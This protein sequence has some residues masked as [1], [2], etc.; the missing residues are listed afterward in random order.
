MA[1][2]H[3]LAVM[4][5]RSITLRIKYI[6][7]ALYRLIEN[8]P[9]ILTSSSLKSISKP[10]THVFYGYYDISPFNNK[11]DEYIFCN[12]IEKENKIHIMLSS[13]SGDKEIELAETKAWNWQQGCRLRWMPNN[14]RE[15]V[16]ND[17]DG[18]NY[19]ARIVNVDT[20]L[21][22]R[23]CTSL[24]DISPNG[25]LGLSIDFERLGSKRPGY[26][27]TC[28]QYDESSHD[29]LNDKIE[30]VDLKSNTKRTLLTYADIIKIP[31][32]KTTNIC[33]NYLNHLCFSP[34]GR[35]FL[36]F[37]LTA[38]FDWHK[39]YLLVHNIE[40]GTTKLLEN[41]DKVSHY[42]WQDEDT[43]ICTAIDEKM[44]WHYKQYN[45]STGEHSEIFGNLL[46]NDGHPSMLGNRILLTDTYPNINGYQKIYVVDLDKRTHKDLIS[47]YS[48]CCYDGERR[49]DL[50]PR[51]DREKK[52]V[53]FD[54][55]VNGYRTLN[56]LSL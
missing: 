40:T 51:L 38:D 18:N 24:Y 46:N 11:T 53:C 17:F 15:I 26:G 31:G 16:F 25:Q 35:K 48:H 49:T 29:L 52:I 42:V 34:S 1:L 39:A 54:A 56:F 30:L 50:H 44:D 9:K 32:C 3:T 33:Q 43:I 47:I 41:S 2:R 6:K 10:Y 22:R 8:K 4:V 7:Q 5:P 55:N 36:F 23:I 21:E 27:Y 28:R 45:V 19:F 37:W 20:K 14:N 13:F 12:L